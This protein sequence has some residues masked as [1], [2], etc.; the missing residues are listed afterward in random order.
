MKIALLLFLLCVTTAFGFSSCN[1]LA[2]RRDLFA[3]KR[4]EGPYTDMIEK[5]RGQK[6]MRNEK[7]RMR[8]VT[9]RDKSK[10]KTYNRSR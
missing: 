3:P 10:T 9:V 5:M 1:T 7:G 6:V 8:M 2:N 4:A